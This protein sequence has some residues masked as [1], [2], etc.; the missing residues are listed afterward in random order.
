M[1]EDYFD[2]VSDADF[3]A[4]AQQLDSRG[5]RRT[6]GNTGLRV[7]SATATSGGATKATSTT[8]VL[9]TGFNAIIVNTRQV[10]PQNGLRSERQ[11]DI[12]EHKEC[13]MGGNTLVACSNIA[14]RRHSSWYRSVRH[15]SPQTMCWGQQHAPSSSPFATIVF[16]QSTSTTGYKSS[17]RNTTS[18]SSWSWL[19]LYPLGNFSLTPGQPF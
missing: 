9:R 19:I 4:L 2:D 16:I 17:E 3:L 5:D 11:P 6:T 12:G 8:R 1:S 10:Q 7:A 14:V 18:A 13:S 15:G